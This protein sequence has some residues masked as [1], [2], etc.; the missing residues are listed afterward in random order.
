MPEYRDQNV[1]IMYDRRDE[2]G[3]PDGQGWFAIVV[4][5]DC[6]AIVP[7]DDAAIAAHNRHHRH[8]ADL[9]DAVTNESAKKSVAP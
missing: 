7:K 6:G 8:V 5:Q 9:G 2:Q 4:C 3:D 1:R